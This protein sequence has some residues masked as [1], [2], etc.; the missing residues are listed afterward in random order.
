MRQVTISRDD[1]YHKAWPSIARAANGNLVVTYKESDGHLNLE[2]SNL[3]VRVSEDQ[4]ETWGERIVLYEVKNPAGDGLLQD[5]GRICA[6]QDGSLLIP[7]SQNA[8]RRD[9]PKGQPY[10][11]RY[12][13]GGR[14]L[15][16]RS[17]DCGYSWERAVAPINISMISSVRQLRSGAILI[18]ATAFSCERNPHHNAQ[19]QVLYRSIDNGR[20]WQGP[21][22]VCD[23]P[24]FQPSEGDFVQLDDGTVVCYIRD[25]DFRYDL[26]V[27][28]T[29]LKCFSHD[30]GLTWEGPYGSG[31]WMYNG[32]MAAGR[33]SNGDVMVTTRLG[34]GKLRPYFG[35]FQEEPHRKPEQVGFW[36]GEF[37][38]LHAYLESQ[39]D[40][41]LRTPPGACYQDPL[42][43]SARW[44]VIDEDLSPHPDFGYSG[45]VNLPSGEVFVV[46]YITDD[47][48]AGRTQIRGYILAPDELQFPDRALTI[49]FAGPR[50]STGPLAGQDDWVHHGGPQEPT[51][52]LERSAGEQ[53]V[54]GRSASAA[55]TAALVST[56]WI[57]PTLDSSRLEAETV[58][59]DVGPFNLY[60][61]TV[62]VKV[63]HRGRAT[64]AEFQL[65]D[66]CQSV[67]AAVASRLDQGQLQGSFPALWQTVDS[68]I[69][70]EDGWWETRFELRPGQVRIFTQPA[71][72]PAAIEPWCVA[73]LPGLQVVAALALKLGG[74]GDVA[75]RHITLAPEPARRPG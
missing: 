59:R 31:R 13:L 63:E 36:H 25:E 15:L 60:D 55:A 39:A 57:A 42:P 21:I 33:L 68:G 27:R 61:E 69:V 10:L 40:A 18:G 5:A 44:F 58:R 20:T 8:P 23:H 71:S 48:P 73:A 34:L 37:P 47:A 12:V 19:I 30:D 3:V 43:P 2:F 29:G 14:T 1:R 66:D 65:L 51:V 72:G 70:L 22:T 16:F 45:W 7:I 6:L 35:T 24:E 52:V 53:V 11:M 75:L 4:G 28:T 62:T 64:F 46:D 67:I 32:R 9:L 41:L 26:P 50:Y 17:H 74:A 56:G 38:L 54:A 49:D